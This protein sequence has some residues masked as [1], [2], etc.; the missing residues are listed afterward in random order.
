M[1]DQIPAH[2]VREQLPAITGMTTGLFWSLTPPAIKSK[3]RDMHAPQ[4][5]VVKAGSDELVEHYIRWC[6]VNDNRYDGVLP[7]HFFAKYGMSMVA[8]VTGMVPYNLMS[9][10]N[11]GCRMQING[12][13]PRGEAIHLK[14]EL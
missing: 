6:G 7:P 2:L 4:T 10:V 3:L 11:Q 8:R 9:V 1:Q 5:D 14:G 12:L 13:I